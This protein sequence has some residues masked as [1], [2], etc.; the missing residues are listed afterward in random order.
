MSASFQQSAVGP[1]TYPAQGTWNR[2][3]FKSPLIYWRMG[4]G[5]ILGRVMLVLTTWGRKSKCPRHTGLSFTAGNGT[6][7]VAS[8]WGARTDWFQNIQVDPHVTVQTGRRAYSALAR[9]VTDLEEFAAVAHLLF[10]TGGDSHF[11]PWLAS[12]GIA[13][14]VDDLIAKHERTYLV[15]LDP[16]D[17]PGPP[18]LPTDLTWVWGV[19]L[20]SFASGWLLGR[21][22]GRTRQR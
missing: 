21:Y 22:A 20:V 18:P 4:L 11:R 10:Q 16:T 5:P 12:L 14:E 9:Q 6:L 7:Y 2:L 1:M 15:A 8:G 13:Y 3:L 19:L 17:E